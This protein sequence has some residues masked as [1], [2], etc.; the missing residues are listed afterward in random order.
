M[1]CQ[2]LSNW[3][4]A[5]LAADLT[6]DADSIQLVAYLQVCPTAAAG[7]V[8]ISHSLA[9]GTGAA[10]TGNYPINIGPTPI[11]TVLSCS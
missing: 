2:G 9:P 11:V 6:P 4:L 5:S 1:F 7:T 3:G 10:I 8:N